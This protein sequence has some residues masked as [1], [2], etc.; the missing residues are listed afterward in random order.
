MV[1]MFNGDY[2]KVLDRHSLE[3]SDAINTHICIVP[4]SLFLAQI[5]GF[6]DKSKL[7]QE[8]YD[9]AR[10]FLEAKVQ[11]SPEDARIHS[12]LGIAYAGL[13]RKEEAIRE[14]K[15]AVEFLPPTKDAFRGPFRVRDLARIYVMVGE[16]DAAIDQLEYLLSI[17][18]EISIP[19][20]KLD[21]TW[22]PL[23]DNPHFQKMIKQGK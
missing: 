18:G 4:K 5:Y 12:S 22:E 20:L 8:H 16:H 21:P 14:G 1:H 7:E 3:S 13:G 10:R 2:Q 17:P 11:E 9:S 15:K 19:L 23:L 6:M